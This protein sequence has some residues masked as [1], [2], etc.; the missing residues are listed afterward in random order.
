MMCRNKSTVAQSKLKGYLTR[1]F[2][3]LKAD[4]KT[5]VK[6]FDTANDDSPWALTAVFKKH[7]QLFADVKRRIDAI[8]VYEEEIVGKDDD[9]IAELKVLSKT[10]LRHVQ[11]KRLRNLDRAD[12]EHAKSLLPEDARCA[13][14]SQCVIEGLCVAV[15]MVA[16]TK[17][18]LSAESE[19]LMTA[20]I[21]VL[22]VTYVLLSS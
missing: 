15:G 6:T 19:A 18:Y 21:Y 17:E 10:G 3:N 20:L 9:H 2:N 8:L 13:C 16:D 12:A 11:H 14:M 1:A 7:N 5:F 4:V 22:R